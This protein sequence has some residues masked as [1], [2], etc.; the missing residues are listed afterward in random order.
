MDV[1]LPLLV[2]SALPCFVVPEVPSKV[3]YQA[4]IELVTGAQRI[5]SGEKLHLRCS[6][7]ED[8]K[9]IWK[10]LWF[11]GNDE[12]LE[13]ENLILYGVSL[14]EDGKYY[15]QGVRSTAVGTLHTVESKPLEINVD[16]G[17]VILRVSPNPCLVGETLSV[18]CQVRHNP[19][20]AEVALYRNDVEV[21]RQK[22]P[23]PH[24]QL[25][26]VT[27]GDQG[28]YTCRA[29]WVKERRS[30]SSVSVGVDVSVMEVLTKPVLEM[31]LG[32]PLIPA[33]MMMLKCLLQYN[34]HAPAPPLHFYY[35]K[36]DYKI[37][38]ASSKNSY[39]VSQTP[40]VYY[41]KARVPELDLMRKSDT[42]TFGLIRA[43][44]SPPGP[45]AVPTR[46]PTTNEIHQPAGCP[47]RP[48][49]SMDKPL[50]PEEATHPNKE[51]AP[52]DD[53]MSGDAPDLSD[54]SFD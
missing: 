26:N 17:W 49:Q 8:K 7:P 29:T 46:P 3:P 40:G 53:L 38:T 28:M 30:Q 42:K 13:S 9:S 16:G 45:M 25:T 36:N 44:F 1:L 50:P 18:T 52:L 33:N 6:V 12:I 4:A 20:I 11:K 51:A 15:C 39:V 48:V 31:V 19:K 32:D 2:F 35:Y 41:C 43:G 24:L 22:G 27:L 10:Y 54:S 21:L 23:N 37:G 47:L 14:T 34:A 5:F